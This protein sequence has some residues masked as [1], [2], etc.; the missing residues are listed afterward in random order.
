MWCMPR[1]K[2]TGDWFVMRDTRNDR[3]SKG[4]KK[5]AIVRVK[6]KTFF[7]SIFSTSLWSPWK[8]RHLSKMILKKVTDQATYTTND[9]S[10]VFVGQVD[11]H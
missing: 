4:T 8:R 2:Y 6:K 3:K 1:Q 11:I 9:L 5:V 7:F 10:S